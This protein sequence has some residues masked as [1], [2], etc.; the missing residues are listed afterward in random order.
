MRTCLPILLSVCLTTAPSLAVEP[1]ISANLVPKARPVAAAEAYLAANRWEVD[2]ICDAIRDAADLHGLPRDY[3]TR[4]IWKESRFDIKAVSPVGAQGIAQFMP[5]TA[6]ARGLADPFDP[7]QAIPASAHYL[8][9]LKAQFG[10]WGLAAAAYNG[11]PDRVSKFVRKRGGLPYE[12]RDYVLSITYRPAE[13]F[14]VRGREVEPR[15]LDEKL[16]FDEAC[17]QIPIVQTRAVLAASV[18]EPWTAQLAAGI[19]RRAA[20]QAL[21]RARKQH[22]KLI[23]GKPTVIRRIKT[24]GVRRYIAGVGV[25]TRSEARRICARVQQRR[26]HCVVRRN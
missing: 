3:F 7:A 20:Q 13:W 12:T 5:A 8:A 4:L 16:A 2:R 9:D 18:T 24:G 21:S 15:P 1:E 6:K 11:G 14:R 17:R 25:A 19:T 10:N 23:G 22:R 26:S